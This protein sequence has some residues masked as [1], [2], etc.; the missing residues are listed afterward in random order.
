MIKGRYTPWDQS[1]LKVKTFEIL[2]IDI[3]D[4][5][6][7]LIELKNN[8]FCNAKLIYGRFPANNFIIKELLLKSGYIPCETSLRITLSKLNDYILPSL[9][10]KRKLSIVE[11]KKN[12]F[13]QIA[14]IAYHMFKFSRFHEDP[15][16]DNSLAD[17]RMYQW[18]FDLAEQDVKCLINKS[19]NNEII[20]FM[21]YKMDENKKVELILG[22]SKKG[23]EMH[24]PYFWGSVISYLK[25]NG[26]IRISTTISAA[27]SGAIT[28]Y[29]NLGFKIIETKLDYHKHI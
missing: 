9:Y 8:S 26:A 18:V 14:E 7:S 24:S 17:N 29:Q 23:F 15:L 20:S 12:D 28:L 6:T 16:I 13:G 4:F 2:E 11:A 19:I 25:I 5:E 22:G 27:N 3:I 10:T 1:A 21:M